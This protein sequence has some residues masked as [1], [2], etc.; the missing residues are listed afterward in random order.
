VKPGT[1]LIA[2]GVV[3]LG[4]RRVYRLLAAARS[5]SISA[6]GGG[7][8]RSARSCRRSGL[9][10]K[11]PDRVDFRL[12]RGPVP[13]LVESFV[14][15]PTASGTEL[16]WEGELG[17]DGGAI[18]EWWGGR[19]ALAWARAVKA[20]FRELAAEAERQAAR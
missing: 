14:L 4:L 19:V 3:G 9:R 10:R 1:A 6:P 15:V 7:S 2:A 5:R 11:R 17:T 12:V 16:R 20:S 8:S 18:G 13:H